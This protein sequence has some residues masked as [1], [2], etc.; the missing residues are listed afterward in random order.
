MEA[1][2]TELPADL[3]RR[4][5]L[6]RAATALGAFLAAAVGIPLVGA[7]VAPAARR[8][9]AQWIKLGALSD[10]QIGEPRMVSFGA[11][12]EDGYLKTTAPRAVWVLRSADDQFTAFNG[13]CTHLGCLVS[14]HPDVKRFI[15]PCHGGEFALDTGAVLDGPPPRGLD[16]LTWRIEDGNL[17]VQHQDFL[18]GVPERVAL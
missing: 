10:F 7:A 13:R 16:Q 9:E 5:F 18:V 12:K 3:E 11:S 15:C 4:A 14:F 8:D 6:S 17:I 2:M 1:R